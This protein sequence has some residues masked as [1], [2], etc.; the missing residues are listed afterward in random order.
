[1]TIR[2]LL[3]SGL[4]ICALYAYAQTRYS[5]YLGVVVYLVT[6]VGIYFVWFPEHTTVIAQLIGL[7]RGTDL[8]LYVWVLLSFLISIHIHVRIRAESERITLLAR[9]IAL[10][11]PYASQVARTDSEQP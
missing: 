11:R 2:V 7:G 1:M 9:E 6:A 8:L 5:R 10:G 3:T 4:L